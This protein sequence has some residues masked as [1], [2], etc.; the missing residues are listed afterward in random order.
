MQIKILIKYIVL[1]K[2]Y[3]NWEKEYCFKYDFRESNLNDVK[4]DKK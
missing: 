1:K 4:K 3:N 2:E